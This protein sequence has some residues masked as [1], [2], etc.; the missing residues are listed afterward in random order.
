MAEVDV[1]RIL[2]QA[3]HTQFLIGRGGSAIKQLEQ[4]SGT[5]IGI[6]KAA[7]DGGAQHK[8]VSISKGSFEALAHSARLIVQ[9]IHEHLDGSSGSPAPP[10]AMKLVVGVDSV[11]R[12]V[13]RKGATV[14][15]IQADS[16]A[17]V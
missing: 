13:G 7:Q 1:L 5:T 11:P 16:G 6:P 14:Q 9:K 8:I 10:T 2:I 3:D 15:K 17:H 4:Q 12:V